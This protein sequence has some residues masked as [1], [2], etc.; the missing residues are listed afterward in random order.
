MGWV[1][2]GHKLPPVPGIG[3]CPGDGLCGVEPV[4]CNGG[5]QGASIHGWAYPAPEEAGD[6]HAVASEA[7][8]NGGLD[9]EVAEV[10]VS[11]DMERQHA[12]LVLHGA[13]D[14]EIGVEGHFIFSVRL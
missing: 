5:G 6:A 10:D 2:V 1:A 12:A 8:R 4:V 13:R 9:A 14:G 11:E 3:L 7:R